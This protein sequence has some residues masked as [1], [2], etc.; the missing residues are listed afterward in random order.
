MA[1]GSKGP[2]REMQRGAPARLPGTVDESKASASFEDGLRELRLPKAKP[3]A[4]D[5]A[6]RMKAKGSNPAPQSREERGMAKT[7][8][9]ATG[10]RAGTPG[11]TGVSEEERRRMIAE[12]AY[13]RAAAR[14]FQ[15][16]DPVQDWLAAEAEIDRMLPPPERQSEERA[17][18]EK[19]REEIERRFAEVREAV[20][21]ET[22]RNAVDRAVVQLKE[23]GGYT[24][25]TINKVAETVKKDL[26]SAA[27]KMGPEWKKFSAKSADAFAVW[28]DRGRGF[29]A[30]AA[31]AVG[32]W[33]QEAGR[34][35]EHPVYRAGEMTASGSFECTACGEKLS[36]ATPGH[37]PPC[38]RCRHLEFRRL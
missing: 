33:L 26:A 22:V 15:G 8:A 19:L 20:N 30:S 25:E 9:R 12:A 35:F 38:P 32:E 17:A 1:N 10:R 37:L 6:D 23:M 24:A 18:Y 16:G 31:T 2:G 13:F 4:P 36:L 7:R 21:A 3:P 27:V 14:G 29:L 5:A 34:R 28:R 11:A